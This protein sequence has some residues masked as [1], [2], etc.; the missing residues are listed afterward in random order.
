MRGLETEAKEK[1]KN[2]ACTHAHV[3]SFVRHSFVCVQLKEETARIEGI[4]KEAKE[5][6]KSKK[7]VEKE[8]EA[9]REERVGTWRDYMSKKGGASRHTYC[10]HTTDV[11]HTWRL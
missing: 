1:H 9:T 3:H 10:T 2:N 4:E 5:K 8:W 6:H 11:W 7:Q